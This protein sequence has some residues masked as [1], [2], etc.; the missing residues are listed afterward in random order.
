MSDT[1]RYWP[2]KNRFTSFWASCGPSEVER[3]VRRPRGV[4]EQPQERDVGE[5]QEEPARHPQIDDEFALQDGVLEE[6]HEQWAVQGRL[7]VAVV[8]GGRLAASDGVNTFR[9]G[10]RPCTRLGRP[11]IRRKPSASVWL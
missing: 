9:G 5:Q 1:S 8:F 10:T 7:F 3:L 6:I 4:D 2:R 11:W